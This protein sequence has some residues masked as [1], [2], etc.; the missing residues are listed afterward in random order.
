M[1]EGTS[2]GGQRVLADLGDE[3]QALYSE[4][5]LFVKELIR[6]VETWEEKWISALARLHAK[7]NSKG[8]SN[9][10]PLLKPL[11]PLYQMVRAPGSPLEK[12]FV[13]RNGEKLMV[14]DEACHR[15]QAEA[16]NNTQTVTP[17]AEHARLRVSAAV[18]DLWRALH[19]SLPPALALRDA[20]PRLA[21]MHHMKLHV[22]GSPIASAPVHIVSMESIVHVISSVHR[23]R[24]LT[25]IGS[26]GAPHSF[27][28]KGKEDVRLDERIMQFLEMAN[29]LLCRSAEGQQQGMHHIITYPVVPVARKVGLFGW[30]DNTENVECVI[31]EVRQKGAPDEFAVAAQ[32]CGVKK[33]DWETMDIAAR[34]EALQIIEQICPADGL[35]VAM[36]IRAANSEVWLERRTAFARSLAIMSIIGYVIG[37]G[38]RHLGNILLH[39]TSGRVAHID[40]EECFEAAMRRKNYPECVPFRLTRQLRNA[41]GAGGAGGVFRRTAICTTQALRTERHA[42]LAL[43]ESFIYEPLAEPTHEASPDSALIL[44]RVHQKLEG[45]DAHTDHT[46]PEPT[47]VSGTYPQRLYAGPDTEVAYPA[48]LYAEEEKKKGY[49]YSLYEENVVTEELEE[50]GSG[51]GG[52]SAF[53]GPE[54]K[55][56]TDAPQVQVDRL[57]DEAS[58]LQHLARM[59]KGW[60][61]WV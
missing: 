9:P 27:L 56:T 46:T 34:V 41:M 50:R 28:L 6:L 3:W 4:A 44:H 55:V 43:I 14:L 39:G 36:W 61:P 22:P 49:P 23:P 5:R 33:L 26:D 59:Y 35:Q 19:K 25:F 29:M 54:C 31:S 57:I 58:S 52:G 30:V 13:Q 24:K 18:L 37:L 12:M 60:R 42:I 2:A 20:T 8:A 1:I 53:V 32:S 15:W 40:F 11:A 21:D 16:A 51:G 48:T 38:D 45:I 7:L 17:H 47:L 10:G